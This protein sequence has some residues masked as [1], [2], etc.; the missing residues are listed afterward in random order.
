MTIMNCMYCLEFKVRKMILK[1]LLSFALV[2]IEKSKILIV[3][4]WWV[5][6]RCENRKE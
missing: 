1:K 2:K 5:M 6:D 3:N 4:H